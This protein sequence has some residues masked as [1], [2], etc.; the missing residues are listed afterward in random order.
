[1]LACLLFCSFITSYLS[2]IFSNPFQ[3]LSAGIFI[4]A[5]PDYVFDRRTFP[6]PDGLAGEVYC[7]LIGSTYILFIFSKASTLT[8]MFLAIDRWYSIIKPIMYKTTFSRRRLYFYITMIW[9][10]SCVSQINELFITVVEDGFCTFRIPFYGVEFERILILV[11][12][13]LTFYIPSIITWCSFAHIKYHMNNPRFRRSINNVKATERLLRMCALAA[14]FLSICWL[15][16]ETFFI[17]YKFDVLRLPFSVSLFLSVLAMFNSCVNPWI[18]C[19]SN[20]EYRKEFV[21]LLCCVRSSSVGLTELIA[22]VSSSQSQYSFTNV[23]ALPNDNQ[24]N[25]NTERSN[26]IEMRAMSNPETMFLDLAPNSATLKRYSPSDLV[27]DR[28]VSQ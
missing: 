13:T 20:K 28:S 8:I 11:H 4:V 25:L 5:T 21:N 17:T 6:Y 15:P 1:M 3:F 16:T 27:P 10:I 19:L 24:T 12:V 7:R 26:V 14:F 18:Y 23:L 9:I 22:R 2:V